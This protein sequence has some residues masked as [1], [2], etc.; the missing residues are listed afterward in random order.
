MLKKLVKLNKILEIDQ[1]KK[2]LFLVLLMFTSVTFEILTLNV[3]F[4]TLSIFSDT[5]FNIQNTYINHFLNINLN[6]SAYIY[7][8]LIFVTTFSLKNFF[9][10]LLSWYEAKFIY[11]TERDLSFKFFKGYL[12]MPRIFHLRTNISETVKI[13]TNEIQQVMFALRSITNICLEIFVLIGMFFFL[14]FINFEI[15]IGAFLLLVIFSTLINYFNIKPI[16]FMGKERV[17]KVKKRLQNIFEG[18]SGSKV[19]QITGTE[20]KIISEFKIN[21]NSI[22]DISR[23]VEFRASLSRPIFEM[24][25]LLLTL[26][27]L[28]LALES[29]TDL[30]TLI[31][32]LGVFLTAA[33]RMVPSFGRIISSIQRLSYSIQAIDKI[34]TDNE[35]FFGNI[36]NSKNEKNKKESFDD[37]ITFSNVSFSYEKNSFSKKNVLDKINIE[38]NKGDKIGIIGK[39]GSGKSTFIDLVLGLLEPGEGRIIID[40][41]NLNNIKKSWQKNIGCV[42]QEVFILDKSLAENIAFGVDKNEIDE[43]KLFAAITQANLNDLVSSLKF[44][45]NTILGEKGSRISG[46]QR[47]RLGIARALYNQP[48]LLIFDEATNSLDEKNEYSIIEEIFR[49]YQDKT[50]IFVSHNL[51]NLRHCKKILQIKD[52]KIELAKNI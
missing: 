23:N 1:K 39:S 4:L 30:K 15:T 28:F 38:I 19:F 16:S 47:Q 5:S 34:Y 12:G 32:I 37:K 3:L 27:F 7:I 14:L 29:K 20:D 43:K 26:F 22:A 11:Y 36:V 45:V 49:N 17:N 2:I 10:I 40:N 42:P 21:N 9:T 6:T 8:F 13:I 50:I 44:G 31:P 24:L 18:I 46:G 25:V 35:K 33:Y 48:E 41:K 51:L 52:K